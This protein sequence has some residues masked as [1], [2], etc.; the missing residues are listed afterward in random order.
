M[1]EPR[2]SVRR[3]A[4]HETGLQKYHLSLAVTF[5]TRS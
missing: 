4:A 2:A 5:E 3:L 1:S